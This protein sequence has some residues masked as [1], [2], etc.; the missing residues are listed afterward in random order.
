LQQ[1]LQNQDQRQRQIQAI[2]TACNGDL[3]R[4]DPIVLQILFCQ[5]NKR[6][7]HS[8]SSIATL[9]DG[10][11]ESSLR[12]N[13]RQF[14][15]NLSSNDVN[16]GL[17]QQ[18]L[19]YQQQRNQQLLSQSIGSAFFATESTTTSN[20][21][22]Q[23]SHTVSQQGT[24]EGRTIIPFLMQSFMNEN[25]AALSNNNI[26]AQLQRRATAP[27]IN[28]GV[29]IFLQNAPCPYGTSNMLPSPQTQQ[30]ASPLLHQFQ[31]LP[32]L[33]QDEMNAQQSFNTRIDPFSSYQQG[34][35]PSAPPSS[36]DSSNIAP[37]QNLTQIQKEQ[38]VQLLRNA[39][40]ALENG[41]GRERQS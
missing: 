14:L 36:Q 31:Q 35:R 22:V 40:E 38:V 41:I 2:L 3:S 26:T 21:P 29:N 1:Q 37:L 20:H 27:P 5:A 33:S 17:R 39:A 28:T 34:S 12:R 30:Q 13:M 24:F 8:D 16:P 15:S 25:P 10:N 19:Q 32:H 11:D 23:E 7:H 9:L 4:V 6:P 18:Q